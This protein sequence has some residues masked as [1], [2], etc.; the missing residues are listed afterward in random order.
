MSLMRTKAL[1]HLLLSFGHKALNS[2]NYSL[3]RNERA[4]T[5]HDLLS[6]A[7]HCRAPAVTGTHSPDEMQVSASIHLPLKHQQFEAFKLGCQV[8]EFLELLS[9]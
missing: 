8:P 4:T 6:L 2:G 9:G 5:I 7:L 3:I 1:C